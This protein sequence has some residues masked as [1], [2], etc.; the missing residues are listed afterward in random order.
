[1][2]T[3]TQAQEMSKFIARAFSNKGV[4]QSELLELMAQSQGFKDWNTFK[5]VDSVNQTKDDRADWT[6]SQY[7]HIDNGGFFFSY[8]T[9]RSLLKVENSFFG[10]SNNIINLKM[11]KK[12]LQ[13]IV[14]SLEELKKCGD[15]LDEQNNHSYK[16]EGNG[17]SIEG[18]NLIFY[19]DGFVMDLGLHQIDLT[20]TKLN[21]LLDLIK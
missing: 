18:F 7:V 12:E 19:K 9:K 11:T 15:F 10:Y 2:V 14:Y 1:M 21:A 8:N 13:K 17:W 16:K 3:A 4:K 6:D 20:I 5:A